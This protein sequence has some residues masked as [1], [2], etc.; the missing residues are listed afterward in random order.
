M[1]RISCKNERFTYD[2][3]HIVKSFLPDAEISQ[4]VDPEQELLIEMTAEEE[5]DLE[6]Q[7][8]DKKVRWTFFHCREAEIADISE[9]RE[10]KRYINKKLYQTL[11]KKTGEE[12]AWG[13]MTG[14][15]PTKMIMERLEEGSSEEEIIRYM[16]DTYVSRLQSGKKPSLTSWIMKMDTVFISEFRSARQPA[17]TAPLLLIRLQNGRT[18]WMNM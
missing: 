4:K 2:M 13:N 10:Q 8:C 16:H 1:I 15:R 18:G 11:V 6:E 17:V 3:Y 7:A 14:V 12:H 5:P 9:K